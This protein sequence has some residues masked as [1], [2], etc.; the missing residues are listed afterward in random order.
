M[1]KAVLVSILKIC[2]FILIFGSLVIGIL[3]QV[4]VPAMLPEL[5]PVIYKVY[6]LFEHIGRAVV[7]FIGAAVMYTLLSGAK[8]DTKKKETSKPERRMQKKTLIGFSI[9]ALVL[10]C[11][12][13][14]ATSFWEF[15]NVLMPLPWSTFPF[16]LLYDGHFFSADMRSAF[17][18]NGVTVLLSAYLVFNAL[19]YTAVLFF[20]RR[21]FCS[22]ICV[23]FGAHA[24]TLKEGFPL[25]GKRKR[26]KNNRMPRLLIPL[27]ASQWL[28]LGANALLIVLWIILLA[29]VPLN[30]GFL[31]SIELAKYLS[32][33]LFFVL[34]AFGFLSGRTY[35]YYCPA[36][37]TLS[38]LDKASGHRIQTNL[39]G[40]IECGKCNTACDMQ[41]DVKS[42]AKKGLPV[43][44]V[45]C[46]G[47]GA[48][49]DSCPVGTLIYK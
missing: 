6:L 14:S 32:L 3:A 10:L 15:Y 47:C 12:L 37:T 7:I 25:F 30:T 48:C 41:I 8:A 38:L 27:K 20:G 28:F 16:Q 49:V 43:R 9:S 2:I 35:C 46:V 19:V 29:G 5:E 21:F 24:E 33:E 13:P 42:H 17:G 40:C 34:F 22:M 26:M 44:S 31:R 39:T 4:V 11:I 23:N 18:G 36:G 45:L 1:S